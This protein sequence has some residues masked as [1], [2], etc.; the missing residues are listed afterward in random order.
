MNLKLTRPL[1]YF[2]LETT[3]LDIKYD[4]IIELAAV[5]LHPDGKKETLHHRFNPE[6]KVPSEVTALTGIKN[7]DVVGA[8]KFAELIPEIS[9][10]FDNADLAGYHI[11]R[12]DVKVLVE[13][14]KR[15]GV[16]FNLNNRK[17][18]DAQSIF[19]QKEKRDLSAA[20]QFY[21]GKELKDAHSAKADTEAT[22]EILEAQLKRYADL[23]KDVDGLHE[24]CRGGNERNVDSEGKFFWRDGEAAFN[25]GKYK[26]QTLR[27][28]AKHHPEYL[29]W[30]ISPDQRFPQE[31]IDICYRAMKGEFPRKG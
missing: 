13:A 10:F 6:M 24:V 7:E 22:L 21:C 8:P 12:F 27:S 30:V 17:L 16:E 3:G 20:Y 4:R 14:F 29:H 26:S 15:A 9:A 1:I 23:P 11:N 18:V 19:H 5:K 31:V 28:V 2:D 25:F